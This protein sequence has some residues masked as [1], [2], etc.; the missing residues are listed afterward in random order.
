MSRYPLFFVY[1]F[2]IWLLLAF[3]IVRHHFGNYFA[4]NEYNSQQNDKE[5]SAIK[6][7]NFPPLQSIPNV[8]LDKKTSESVM[9]VR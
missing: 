8:Y 2:V 3:I 1:T 4:S 7:A 9:S 5:K 6:I